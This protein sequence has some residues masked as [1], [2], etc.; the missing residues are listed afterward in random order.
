MAQGQFLRLSGPWCPP[1]AAQVLTC[2]PAEPLGGWDC[3]AL[4][5]GARGRHFPLM[6]GVGD[7][8]QDTLAFHWKPVISLFKPWG[9]L[10][11]AATPQTPRIF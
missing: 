5:Q 8:E 9:L 11:Q 10:F 4:A 2:T 7:E 6:V 1:V 3:L